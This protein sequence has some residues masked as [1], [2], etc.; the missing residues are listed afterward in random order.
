MAVASTIEPPVGAPPTLE[1]VAVDRLAIDESYQR[2]TDSAA[3]R[4]LILQIR[5][6]WNWNYCQPL[7]VSR[8]AD[9]SLFVIDG[10]HRLTAAMQRGDIP[11]LPCVVLSNMT[12]GGEASAFV[13]LNTRRQKLSQG[14]IFNAM[15]AAGDA[16]AAVVAGLLAETGW[17]MTHTSNTQAWKAGDLFCA[18][19]IVK[20][21]KAEGECIVRNAL[22]AL[23][24]AYPATTVTNTATMLKALFLIYRGKRVSDPDLLIE[25]LGAVA[26]CDWEMERHGLRLRNPQLSLNEALV[27]TIVSACSDVEHENKVAA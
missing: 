3:S 14:D 8:R 18:P 25:T 21:L 24:E 17:R 11:H 7:V 9:A 20:A 1:W 22:T 23:R 15:L 4:R 6:R 27:E 12:D 19:M 26:P 13:A 10:Q 16:S 2:A 5:T